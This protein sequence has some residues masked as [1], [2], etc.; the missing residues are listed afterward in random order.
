MLLQLLDSRRRGL[1]VEERADVTGC[2]L[3][4][5][6]DTVKLLI[7]LARVAPWPDPGVHNLLNLEADN[8]RKE[9]FVARCFEGCAHCV[10]KL[11]LLLCRQRKIVGQQAGADV[12]V[13]DLV[14]G[15]PLLPGLFARPYQAP[16]KL[17]P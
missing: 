9:F 7:Q 2:G 17:S 16:E 13:H 15:L 3:T 14:A 10:E 8:R 5:F 11:G 12:G 1:S 6:P 4:N